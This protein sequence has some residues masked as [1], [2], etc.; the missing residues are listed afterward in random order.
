MARKSKSKSFG[1][2]KTFF[3]GAFSAVGGYMA[4]M[5]AIS[6]YTLLIAG[7][8]YYLVKSNNKKSTDGQETPLFKDMS[9]LQYFG[10]FLMVIG[11][12]PFMVYFFQAFMF[13]LGEQAGEW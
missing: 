6:L 4:M 8:G 5:T 9:A 7:S 11:L 12:A 2:M 13:S 3:A 10:A 1:F